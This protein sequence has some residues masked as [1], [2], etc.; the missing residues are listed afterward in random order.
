[1][2]TRNWTI[3]TL[4]A[5][6]AII[7]A[8]IFTVNIVIDPYGEFRII[9]SDFNKFKFKTLNTSALN[10]ASKLYDGKYTLVFGSSRTMLV[11]EEILGG[12]VLNF[13]SSI[14]NNPGDILALLKM[15]DERQIKNIKQIY[16]LI[17][18]N[19][20]HYLESAPELASKTTF[21]LEKFRNIGPN[22]LKDAWRC[23]LD[24]LTPHPGKLNNIDEFG[25]LHKKET[26]YK[27]KP[28][29]FSS[30]YVTSYYL[31][32]LTA[33]D[34]LCEKNSIKIIYFSIPWAQPFFDFQQAKLNKILDRTARACNGF[35]DL[36][37]KTELTGKKVFFIDPSHLNTKGLK[38]LFQGPYWN[39][40]GITHASND[41]YSQPN[42]A[43]ITNANFFNYITK[44]IHSLDASILLNQLT[45]EKREDL[46]VSMYEGK[47]SIHFPKRELVADS[48]LYGRN[49]LLKALFASG[50][51]FN[52]D[53][54]TIDACLFQAIMSGN[55]KIIKT[56]L[57][58]GADVNSMNNRGEPP[59]STATK[60]TKGTEIVHF[61]L[62]NG[63]DGSYINKDNTVPKA[64]SQSI[65][66]I[67][68][69][70]HDQKK[71]NLFLK[72]HQGNP[73]ARHAELMLELEQNP[74]NSTAYNECSL[75][76]E[77]YYSD[78]QFYTSRF[79]L[80][81]PKTCFVEQNNKKFYLSING[82]K[83]NI[84]KHIAYLFRQI[85]IRNRVLDV[86]D[87]TFN[88]LIHDNELTHSNKQ[89]IRFFL[90]REIH[91]LITSLRHQGV[92]K[93][94]R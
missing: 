4:S 35:Y 19:S 34:A 25:V 41:N 46:I 87:N 15:L 14:Y 29:I 72:N 37:L 60:A 80:V 55:I 89:Q 62:K 16:Y 57:A 77:K 7:F 91:S 44:N 58:L 40:N 67:A 28:P 3:T 82:K 38:M 65:F 17:D 10:V 30:H 49:R 9:E 71:L 8:L 88:E 64:L 13:S 18:I 63:A 50:H 93:E 21:F 79:F 33:I 66:T 52:T 47:G 81:N 76:Q 6:A 53:Q 73:I 78:G 92:L 27:D 42:L 90:S 12:P 94:L 48:F 75:L 69:D 68:F 2:S 83:H 74:N 39:N 31:E 20:F 54:Q 24:N 84:P 61:L 45:A 86:V 32:K 59:L 43:T 85:C 51:T 22:K 23:L 1:M 26:P 70:N 5:L 11:S 56:A 36:H